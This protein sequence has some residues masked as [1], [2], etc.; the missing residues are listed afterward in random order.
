MT[1]IEFYHNVYLPR[2]ADP[3][4]K[5]LHLIGVP[6][7]LGYGL[8]MA[9]LGQWWLL[10]LLPV[11]VYLL[12]W[13]GHLAAGNQPTSFEHPLLSF[14]AYWKMYA[15]VLSGRLRGAHGDG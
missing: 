3:A 7:A 6:V 11:P 5:W 10:A 13:L 2:H 15:D 1:F 9:W 14:L 4:C 12:G 8:L